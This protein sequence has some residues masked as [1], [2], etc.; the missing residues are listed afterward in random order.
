[1]R[2]MAIV[3]LQKSIADGN[4]KLKAQQSMY[5]LFAP[6][7]TCT[8]RTCSAQDEIEICASLRS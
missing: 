1:M 6:T 2:E 8:A 4:A 7:A 3:D 5:E